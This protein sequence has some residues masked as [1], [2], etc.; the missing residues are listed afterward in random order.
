VE[1]GLVHKKGR[2]ESGGTKIAEAEEIILGRRQE[3]RPEWAVI[4]DGGAN[5]RPAGDLAGSEGGDDPRS[6][7]EWTKSTH[8]V[9]L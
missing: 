7:L 8:G 1:S 3:E 6:A 4:Q 9:T 2:G 5:D